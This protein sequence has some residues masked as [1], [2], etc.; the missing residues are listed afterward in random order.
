MGYAEVNRIWFKI[1]TNQYENL[2]EM[3]TK[4]IVGERL[5]NLREAFGYTRETFAAEVGIG[6]AQVARYERGENDATGEILSRIAKLFGVSADYLLGLTDCETGQNGPDLSVQ[7]R[8]IVSALRRGE[9]WAVIR[10][11][12]SEEDDNLED[13]ASCAGV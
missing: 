7:E 8:K 2:D 9:R 10:M 3:V 5:R 6:T 12:A 1:V 4:M 13:T 11:V